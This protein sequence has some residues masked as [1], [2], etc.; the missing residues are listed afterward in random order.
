MNPYESGTSGLAN[1]YGVQ[2]ICFVDSFCTTVFKRF[3]SWIRFVRPKISKD[4]I[5]FVL[6]GFVYESRILKIYHFSNL[7]K[8]KSSLFSTKVQFDKTQLFH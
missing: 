2:K 8:I 3:V 7:F 5:H 4:S 6:E 1:T